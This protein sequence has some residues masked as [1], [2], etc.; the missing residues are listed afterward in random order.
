M[1]SY[2]EFPHSAVSLTIADGRNDYKSRFLF[3]NGFF[4]EWPRER[5]KFGNDKGREGLTR[6]FRR[7]VSGLP[8]KKS[9]IAVLAQ[10]AVL[11]NFGNG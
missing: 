4:H 5:I 1:V 9:G 6:Q 10:F 11:E 2:E 8:K 3:C 7:E